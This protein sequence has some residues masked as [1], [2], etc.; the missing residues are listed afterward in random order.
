MIF[1]KLYSIIQFIISFFIGGTECVGCSSRTYSFVLCDNCKKKILNF[2]AFNSNKRCK[3][4]GKILISEIGLC[5]ECKTKKENQIA[6]YYDKIFPMH[7][8][9][10][11]YKDLIYAWKKENY[12]GLGLLFSK[13]Y[14]DSILAIQKSYQIDS[15]VCIPERPGKL[16]KKGWDQM[17]DIK[18]ILS[19]KYAILIDDVFIRKSETEQKKLSKKEREDGLGTEY[20]FI[21]N[22]NIKGGNYLILDDVVTT[23]NTMNKCAKLLKNRGAKNVYGL[24]LFIVD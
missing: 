24:S 22:I 15:I 23:G 6:I 13:L 18:N 4:C 2:S 20:E 17:K 11:W 7:M 3:I 14:F 16:K 5:N 8:Y 19:R 12:R 21:E 10:L 9:R 1:E